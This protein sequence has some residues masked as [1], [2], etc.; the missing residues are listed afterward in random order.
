MWARL[1]P[2]GSRRRQGASSPRGSNGVLLVALEKL[3]RNAL[4]AAQEADAHA[5]ADGG[6]LLRELDALGLDVGRDRVNVLHGEAEM[7]EALIG[8]KRWGVDAVAR[9]DRGDE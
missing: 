9:A 5:G 8:R 3:D 1:W 6:R 7:V 4:R 2:H